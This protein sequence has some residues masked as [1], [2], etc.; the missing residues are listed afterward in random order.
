[1]DAAFPIINQCKL[2]KNYLVGSL[3]SLDSMGDGKSARNPLTLI[4]VP[5]IFLALFVG[6]T[7]VRPVGQLV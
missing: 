1:M 4:V 5:T 6:S 2:I 7:G 3:P